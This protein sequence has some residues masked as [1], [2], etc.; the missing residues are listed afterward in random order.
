MKFKLKLL[1]TCTLDGQEI[2]SGAVIELDDEA[3]YNRLIADASAE[4]F[5]EPDPREEELVAL[6]AENQRQKELLKAAGRQPVAPK[7]MVTII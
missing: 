1:K 7:A 5:V 3:E 2:P 6:R 4:K